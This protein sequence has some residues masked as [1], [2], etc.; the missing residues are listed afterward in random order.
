MMVKDWHDE[1]MHKLREDNSPIGTRSNCFIC[2][3]INRIDE[4]S[5]LEEGDNIIVFSAPEPKS[6]IHLVFATK[7]HLDFR[8]ALG[9]SHFSKLLVKIADYC[10]RN[11][12]IN[13][14]ILIDNTEAYYTTLEHANAQL[15]G[16]R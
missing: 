4:A 5:I 8:T 11:D 14:K 9:V 12:I 10:L 2:N 3:I 6:E 13:F 16:Y 1:A 7:A 15:L